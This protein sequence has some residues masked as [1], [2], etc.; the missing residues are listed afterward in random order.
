MR[1]IPAV[2]SPM[3]NNDRSPLQAIAGSDPKLPELKFGFDTISEM[4]Y[5]SSDGL[6]QHP[7]DGHAGYV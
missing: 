3:A 4:A 1:R 2:Q 5:F 6:L 7:R